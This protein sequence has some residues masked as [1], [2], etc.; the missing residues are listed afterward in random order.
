MVKNKNFTKVLLLGTYFYYK[1]NKK[2]LL[3]ILY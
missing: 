3:Y 2:L 1:V